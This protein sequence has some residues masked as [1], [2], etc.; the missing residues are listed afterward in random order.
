[1]I[2]IS[3]CKYCLYY[4]SY[5]CRDLSHNE[6]NSLYNI[7]FYN[8]KNLKNLWV[9]FRWSLLFTLWC[10]MWFYR[11]V[12]LQQYH[13]LLSKLT[14]FICNLMR[15]V[16]CKKTSE[17]LTKLEIQFFGDNSQ[18]YFPG[19]QSKIEIFPIIKFYFYQMAFFRISIN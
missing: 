3:V 6:I 14:K 10:C 15:C 13:Q 2:S 8:L 18:H 9:L 12:K 11:R 5:S 16:L 4:K 1:M 7:S 19:L 17:I